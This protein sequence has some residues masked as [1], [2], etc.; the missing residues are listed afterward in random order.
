[1]KTDISLYLENKFKNN[2]LLLDTKNLDELYNN[3]EKI[4]S[5]LTNNFLNNFERQDIKFNSYH[6]YKKTTLFID[7]TV[8]TINYNKQIIKLNIYHNNENLDIF[9]NNILLVIYFMIEYSNFKKDVIIDYLLTDELKTI[10]NLEKNQILTKKEINSG[11][12]DFRKN[13]IIIWRKEEIMKVTIHEL[14]HLFNLGINK[15]SS[16]LINHYKKKYKISSNNIILDEAYTEFLAVLINI[17][18][19]TKFTKKK[20]NYFKYLLKLEIYFSIFQSKKI[21]YISKINKD[22]FIDINKYTQ[23]LSYFI[24]KL[25]LFMNL[26]KVLKLIN[27]KKINNLE[28]LLIN[29]NKTILNNSITVKLDMKIVKQMRMTLNELKLF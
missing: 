20:Y 29:F 21:M 4:Y 19:I 18:L 10:N 26:D 1:M 2:K 7:K 25:E 28:K 22:H 8:I 17:Y 5:G 14:I 12:T 24:I 16:K 13:K 15:T 27:L 23:V 9:L 3:F 6:N 11:L